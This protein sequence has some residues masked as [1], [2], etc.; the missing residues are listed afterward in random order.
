MI[1]YFLFALVNPLLSVGV[2]RAERKL[3]ADIQVD[4]VF[5]R[6]ETYAPTQLFPVVFAI[7]NFDSVAPLDMSISATVQSTGGPEDDDR[8]V[9]KLRPVGLYS[10]TLA[11]AY[12]EE[13]RKHY[14]HFT[15]VNMTNGTTDTYKILWEVQLPNLC[16]ANNTYPP[17]DDGGNGWSNSENGNAMRI[18]VFETAPGGQLPDIE[19]VVNSCR[20]RN[21]EDSAAFRITEVRKTY[22]DGK[23]CPVIETNV[24]PKPCAF[25]SDAEELAANVSTEM[26]RSLGCKEG[27][28]RTITAPCPREEES[29]AFPW[30]ADLGVGWVLLG[31]A[32]S[33]LNL[34]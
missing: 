19:A 10:D 18:G 22:H 16:H 32:F 26:L 25:K 27:D 3:P 34:L 33:A 30:T 9:W 13:P 15:G 29:M 28:W 4:L 17:D 5:P 14:F 31:L 12:A 6:N 11:E 21:G 23:T 7:D 1:F 24:K 8:P 20:E 2:A